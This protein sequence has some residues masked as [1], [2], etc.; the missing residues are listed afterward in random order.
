MAPIRGTHTIVIFLACTSLAFAQTPKELE[1]PNL[2]SNSRFGHSVS[3]DS[4]RVAIGAIGLSEPGRAFVF[5]KS[6][7]W[8]DPTE[9]VP[10]RT[11]DGDG[12][13][14]SVSLS[15]DRLAISS[16]HGEDN[17]GGVSVFS[18]DDGQSWV[19]ETYLCRR[20][21]SERV[22]PDP[23]LPSPRVQQLDE[24]GPTVARLRVARR[25][26]GRRKPPITRPLDPDRILP[27]LTMLQTDER[28]RK[29]AISEIARAWPVRRGTRVTESVKDAFRYPDRLLLLITDRIGE[30]AHWLAEHRE[31]LRA[32]RTVPVV[33]L[34]LEGDPS[35][36]QLAA[37]IDKGLWE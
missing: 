20:D 16:R 35:K 28:R 7:G 13:G 36:E 26:W 25:G 23:I 11:S 22:D 29:M 18:L 8:E 34:G 14:Q 9:I 3:M 37:L 12:F 30:T 27:V 21:L 2:G 32:L 6:L 19:E 1:A 31:S 5:E 15:A 33:L 4:D 24:P 17:K 10:S